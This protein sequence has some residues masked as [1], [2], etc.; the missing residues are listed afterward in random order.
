MELHPHAH[1]DVGHML[2]HPR[3][4]TCPVIQNNSQ[5]I[6]WIWNDCSPILS[7]A[8]HGQNLPLALLIVHLWSYP[9]CCSAT[10]SALQTSD[11]SSA[12]YVTHSCFLCLVTIVRTN[13]SGKGHLWI[14][15]HTAAKTRRT[16]L[17]LFCDTTKKK[18]SFILNNYLCAYLTRNNRRVLFMCR[19]GSTNAE[20]TNIPNKKLKLSEQQPRARLNLLRANS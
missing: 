18:K 16:T 13:T 1:S 20:V 6:I 12:N 9:A 10:S 3:D 5:S 11:G 8:M 7:G 17:C 19:V 2:R 14:D 15:V 4:C